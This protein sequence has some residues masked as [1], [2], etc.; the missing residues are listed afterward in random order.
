MYCGDMHHLLTFSAE[1]GR[2][3]IQVFLVDV[4][5]LE[6]RASMAQIQ[7]AAR[8]LIQRCAPSS[9]GVAINIGACLFTVL[10]S[11]KSMN[12]DDTQ[13]DID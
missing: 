13:P 11:S 8:A 3:S 10:P 5:I 6:A 7:Q 1:D 9:G 4:R 12:A 2:C